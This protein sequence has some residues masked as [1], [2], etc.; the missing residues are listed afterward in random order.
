MGG[1]QCHTER[2]QAREGKLLA[3]NV[4][5]LSK[6]NNERQPCRKYMSFPKSSRGVGS[7]PAG[8]RKF[9]QVVS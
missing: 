1:H 8:A 2:T 7:V 6:K 5:L 4:L 9:N 3:H